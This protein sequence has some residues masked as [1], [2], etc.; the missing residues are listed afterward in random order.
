MP[1]ARLKSLTK[2]ACPPGNFVATVGASCELPAS[3]PWVPNGAQEPVASSRDRLTVV[4]SRVVVAVVRAKELS[5]NL[6]TS[7]QLS[8]P[9]GHIGCSIQTLLGS[10]CCLSQ[11]NR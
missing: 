11:C 8:S 6:L 9:N 3:S 1:Q 5:G 4:V 10:G 2:Q 7:P